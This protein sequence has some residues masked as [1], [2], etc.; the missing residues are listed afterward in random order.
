MYREAEGSSASFGREPFFMLFASQLF[1]KLP[2][3]AAEAAFRKLVSMSVDLQDDGTA[4]FLA[5]LITQGSSKFPD[6][7]SRLLLSPTLMMLEEDVR[8]R[9]VD[10]TK[11]SRVSWLATRMTLLKAVLDGTSYLILQ[12]LSCTILYAH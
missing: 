6:L 1:Y 4:M 7:A 11:A 9:K 12:Q 10:D 5:V 3:A 8:G 2:E